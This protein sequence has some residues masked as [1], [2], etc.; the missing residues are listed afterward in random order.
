MKP[1]NFNKM[2]FLVEYECFL[3]E[4]KIL[5]IIR[6][7]DNILFD[8]RQLY[9]GRKTKNGICIIYPE[10]EWLNKALFGEYKENILE[11]G[12]RKV[13][14]LKGNDLKIEVQKADNT[15]RNIELSPQE[16][17]IFLDNMEYITIRI[18]DIAKN[19]N[20]DFELKN[21]KE[22]YN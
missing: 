18:K 21:T 13:T 9:N 7:S 15:L 2:E 5:Q 1:R 22:I 12:R 20:A 11:H 3:S 6:T 16:T 14:V 8:I 17:K 19:I 4:D 10:F